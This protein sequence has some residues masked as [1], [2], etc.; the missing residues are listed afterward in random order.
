MREPSGDHTGSRVDGASIAVSWRGF[1][2][3]PFMIQISGKSPRPLAKTI[4]RPS[5]DQPGPPSLAALNV[6]CCCP[7]PSAFMMKISESPSRLLEKTI[8]RPSGDHRGAES[9]AALSV[10]CRTAVPSAAIT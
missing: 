2:P 3:F 1:V 7:D 5:G 9:S 10:S 4:S 6:S 8:S